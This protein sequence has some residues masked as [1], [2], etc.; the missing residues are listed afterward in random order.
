[1]TATV[2]DFQRFRNAR[3][4]GSS[5]QAAA[6]TA[7]VAVEPAPVAPAEPEIIVEKPAPVASERPPVA[8]YMPAYCDP[9]NERRG[10]KFIKGRDT[11][12]IAKAVRADIAAAIKSGALP[13]IKV[14]VKTDRFSMGTSIDV[15]VREIPAGW[16]V[17]NP[18]YV[19]ALVRF[20]ATPEGGAK[21]RDVQNLLAALE[22]IAREYQRDNSSSQDDH[23]DVNFHLSVELDPSVGSEEYKALEKKFRAE[24][25]Y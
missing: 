8:P 17:Y 1:M 7:P 22:S 15:R 9:R 21:S 6:C 12:D 20:E 13:A 2:I 24:R 18:D 4:Q 11:A 14:S 5:P 16:L 10:S 19:R 3:A 25:G 23:T